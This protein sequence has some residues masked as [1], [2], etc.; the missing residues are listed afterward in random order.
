M[1]PRLCWHPFC[2]SVSR[3]L[4]TSAIEVIAINFYDATYVDRMHCTVY[5]LRR[6]HDAILVS[7][8]CYSYDICQE[9]LP[10]TWTSAR[11][12]QQ[13]RNVQHTPRRFFIPSAA[14]PAPDD[15][16]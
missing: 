15:S 14:S 5:E 16:L 12:E 9:V 3:N 10:A 6:A 4:Q 7:R 1:R 8:L 2:E 11:F 13:I